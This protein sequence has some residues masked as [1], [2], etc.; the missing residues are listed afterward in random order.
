MKKLAV[1]TGAGISAES[2]L[3]TFRDKGG[4]WEKYDFQKLASIEGWRENPELVLEF[5]NIRR[6]LVRKAQPNAAHLAL[7]QLERMYDVDIITQNVDDLHERAGSKHIL[8]LHG[9]IM[10]ARSSIDDQLIYE[11]GEKNIKLGDKCEKGSQLRPHVVW[12]GE[13]VP[14]MDRAIEIVSKAEIFIIIGTSLQVYPAAS[15]LYYAPENSRIYLVDK[16]IPVV[17]QAANMTFIAKTAVEGVPE[18][19]NKLL[20]KDE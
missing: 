4:L 3:Q 7:T 6:D 16:N 18:L 19:V 9:E 15:L 1:L 5:Y 17:R 8:H 12:F 2:G 20:E 10:K 13:S 14:M 11:L